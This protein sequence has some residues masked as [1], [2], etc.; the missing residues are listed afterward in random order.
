LSGKS[1][2]SKDGIV[3]L[4]ETNQ[5]IMQYTFHNQFPYPNSEIY[6][7]SS[8][9]AVLNAIAAKGDL[10]TYRI[11]KNDSLY[12]D[13]RNEPYWFLVRFKDDDTPYRNYN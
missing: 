13:S 3:Y 11:F 9:R 12:N 1:V 4:K 2:Y 6:L 8:E 7:T 5:K 10:I